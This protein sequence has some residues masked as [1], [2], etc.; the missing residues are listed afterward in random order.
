MNIKERTQ[1]VFE[2]LEMQQHDPLLELIKVAKDNS[3][4]LDM[5][6]TINKELLQYAAPKLKAVDL[7]ANVEF[8]GNITIRS[9]K[10]ATQEEMDEI[11]KR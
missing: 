10:D 11:H 1:K 7:T 4:P 6:V 2:A 8:D 5:K 3:T 9:F